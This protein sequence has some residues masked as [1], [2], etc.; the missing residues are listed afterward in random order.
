MLHLAQWLAKAG[1]GN[2][3]Q[4]VGGYRQRTPT[5][6]E[7][8]SFSGDHQGGT[9]NSLMGSPT[10]RRVITADPKKPIRYHLAKPSDIRALLHPQARWVFR[11]ETRP[12]G[13]ELSQHR[14]IRPATW[15]KLHRLQI[16]HKVFEYWYRTLQG[17]IAT[18][19]YRQN[20]GL[21]QDQSPYCPLCNSNA[22]EDIQHFWIQCPHKRAIWS[23][24]FAGKPWNTVKFKVSK[25]I[26]NVK[27]ASHEDIEKVAWGMPTIWRTHYMCTLNGIPR[28]HNAIRRAYLELLPDSNG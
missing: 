28:S 20:L 1:M 24:V 27:Q 6:S 2:G 26:W 7:I 25:T 15:K 4:S 11:P 8:P 16:P 22:I 21:L 23:Y 13:H 14:R 9:G 5:L 12:P 10:G 3:G 19:Q 17:K 18:T